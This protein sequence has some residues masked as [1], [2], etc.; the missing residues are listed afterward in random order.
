MWTALTHISG[1]HED[2][3]FKKLAMINFSNCPNI[4]EKPVLLLPHD[5]KGMG[6][7]GWLWKQCRDRGRKRAKCLLF[8]LHVCGHMIS[9]EL[10]AYAGIFFSWIAG[11]YKPD[12]DCKITESQIHT[13]VKYPNCNLPQ[14]TIHL[15]FNENLEAQWIGLRTFA[16]GARVSSMVGDLRIHRS[17]KIRYKF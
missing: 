14:L 16:T 10:G 15:I 5:D 1:C 12:S 7:V 11:G 4:P 2:L 13:Y 6:E 8:H 9:W 17:M 3:L